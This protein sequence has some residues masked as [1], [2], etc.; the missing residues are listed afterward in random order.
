GL[1]GPRAGRAGGP[2]RVGA[3]APG[4]RAGATGPDAGRPVAVGGRSAPAAR[5]RM[6]AERPAQRAGRARRRRVGRGALRAGG[7]AHG[8]EGVERGPAH[9][10]RGGRRHGGAPGPGSARPG[11][12]GPAERPPGAGGGR[13]GGPRRGPGGRPAGR[14]TGPAAGRGRARRRP[15]AVA[16]RGPRGA[17]AGPGGRG[18][19]ARPA[20][21]GRTG[22][23]RRAVRA[24]VGRPAEGRGR[25]SGGAGRA[26]RLRVPARGLLRPPGRTRGLRPAGPGRTPGLRAA[27]GPGTGDV[28]ARRAGGQRRREDD[29]IDSRWAGTMTQVM[30]A[31]AASAQR[32]GSMPPVTA[33]AT[34]A[35]RRT[36]DASMPVVTRWLLNAA[37]MRRTVATP[38]ERGRADSSSATARPRRARATSTRSV[39]AFSST[40]PRAVAMP[41]D[42]Q[43]PTPDSAAR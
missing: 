22:A 27:V 23:H 12:R 5:G 40:T 36:R 29:R 9:G 26:R 28:R 7:A 10:R 33:S 24:G 11:D 21:R 15:A 6:G 31:R 19:A 38:W 4:G 2:G 43:P 3:P 32:V 41:T 39:D 30:T 8:G 18:G 37:A 20:G 16:G 35:T 25:W 17:P 34:A 13:A 42:S 1:R 14:G